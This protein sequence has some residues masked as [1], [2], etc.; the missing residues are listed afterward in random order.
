MKVQE[1]RTRRPA[2]ALDDEEERLNRR[3]EWAG[4]DGQPT[5]VERPVID[6]DSNEPNGW[7][8][9]GVTQLEVSTGKRE[10][11]EH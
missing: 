2:A 1:D 4:P 3:E 11:K 7:G 10:K 5:E 9:G 6:E 8:Q